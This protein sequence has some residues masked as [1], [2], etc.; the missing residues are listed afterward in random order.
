M[1][2]T[3]RATTTSHRM[4]TARNFMTTSLVTLSPETSIFGA[5]R[6]LLTKRISGAPVIDAEGRVVGVLSEL[7]CLRVLSS[8]EFYAG[9][10]EESGTVRDFMSRANQ[11]IPPEM[12]LYAIAHYFLTTSVRRLPVV[13]ESNQLVGLLSLNDI[14]RE[15]VRGGPS[16]RGQVTREDV[17]DTLAAICAPRVPAMVAG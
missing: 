3:Q 8:D 11:T 13:D 17:A 10:Q 6:V 2:A 15:A 16:A 12:D 7:D 14:A 5:I 1:I 4:P 9:Q